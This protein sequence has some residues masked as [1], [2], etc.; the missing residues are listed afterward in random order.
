[1]NK[2]N[3]FLWLLLAAFSASWAAN[4]PEEMK[5]AAEA[6]QR[7]E[8]ELA[9][10]HLQNAATAGDA[11]AQYN[12]SVAYS[13]GDGVAADIKTALLWLQKSAE[14]G[15][16]TAQYDLALYYLQQSNLKLA[17]QWMK[18]AAASGSA[19]AA[20]NYGMMLMR[21]DGVEKNIAEGKRYLQQAAAQKFP[22]A[23]QVLSSL[24]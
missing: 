13:N 20:F 23:L 8:K 17:A 14:N 7:G 24:K 1:M 12:L 11:I 3:T 5:A 19:P 22:P 10:R 15:Y 21:G 4:V 9:V 6:Y 18:R 2:H 16:Q